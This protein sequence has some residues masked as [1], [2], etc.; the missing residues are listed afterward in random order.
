[1]GC[2]IPDIRLTVCIGQFPTNCSV[3]NDFGQGCQRTHGNWLRCWEGAVATETKQPSWFCSGLARLVRST[4][5]LNISTNMYILWPGGR[6]DSKALGRVLL[7][8]NVDRQTCQREAVNAIFSV[9]NPFSK[10]SF[11]PLHHIS[12]FFHQRSTPRR[13]RCRTA[14]W[15]ASWRSS[16]SAASANAA[17]VA[18]TSA[19][20]SL[21]A[22]EMLRRHLPNNCCLESRLN[23]CGCQNFLLQNH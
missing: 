10:W 20:A 1:M 14:A 15:T 2:D 21:P 12:S 9:Q 4:L 5:M 6:G 19:T 3:I 17:Q 13:W 7:E 22:M 11:G 23:T 8:Q 16:V 18:L